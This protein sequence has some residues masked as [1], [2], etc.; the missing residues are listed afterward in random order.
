MTERSAPRVFE[1]SAQ[2]P[3]PAQRHDW[4]ATR[5]EPEL[6][7][8]REQAR[9][10]LHAALAAPAAASDPEGVTAWAAAELAAERCLDLA[11]GWAYDQLDAPRPAPAALPADLRRRAPRTGALACQALTAPDARTRLIFVEDLLA[12]LESEG[13]R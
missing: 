9:A 6:D 2:G 4:R 1:P 7:A 5:L 12:H 8:A 11:L 3:G 13:A 10:A